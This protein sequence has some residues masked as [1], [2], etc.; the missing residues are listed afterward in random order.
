MRSP[1]ELKD[2]SSNLEQV[3]DLRQRKDHMLRAIR[4]LESP[5]R[6]P[7]EAHPAGGVLD[8]RGCRNVEDLGRSGKGQALSG[9]RSAP[10]TGLCTFRSKETCASWVC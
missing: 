7:I 4:N 3:C 5:L 6:A 10:P 9:P 2:S 8:E 1:L